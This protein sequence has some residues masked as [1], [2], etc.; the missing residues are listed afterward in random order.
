LLE[1]ELQ[2]KLDMKYAFAV[3]SGSH[4]MELAMEILDLS[5]G[6]VILP[7]FT[8]PSVANAVLRAGGRP[9]F[10]EIREPDLN[11]DLQHALSLISRRTKAIVVTHYAGHPVNPEGIPIPVI[12]DAAHALGSSLQNRSCG[13]MG[14]VGCLSFHQT[15]NCA[16]GEGGA[17]LCRSDEAAEKIRIFREKGT[18]REE[19]LSRRAPFYSWVGLGSS[20]VLS[21]VSAA[22][23]RVQLA[24]LDEIFL[25]RRRIAVWYDQAFADLE[26]TGLLKI[27]RPL[28]REGSSYHIYG[29]LVNPARRASIL[30]AMHAAG[31][32]TAHH[33][34]PLH[35]SPYGRKLNSGHPL[36]ETDRLAASLIRLPIYP[37]LGERDLETIALALTGALRAL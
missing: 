17:I 3:S 24:K 26:K 8:F 5:G 7:S 30:A 35:S 11:I 6:E 25:R 16:A 4:A 27:V 28:D 15:K 19:F 13:T 20:F 9:I 29:I 32:G 2:S 31:I 18:N 37:E 14:Q 22:I 34:M 21:E 33:F 10:C 36:P 23:T 1:E 12:E